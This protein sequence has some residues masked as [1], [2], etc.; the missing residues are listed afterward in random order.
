[1]LGKI[2]EQNKFVLDSTKKTA[3]METSGSSDDDM[4][5]SIGNETHNHYHQE[6]NTETKP[7]A[8]TGGAIK[9]LLAAALLGGGIGAGYIMSQGSKTPDFTDTNTHAVYT[10]EGGLGSPPERE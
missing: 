6:T 9:A 1:M 4:G 3:G 2:Q 8:S 5:V 7:E 10:M